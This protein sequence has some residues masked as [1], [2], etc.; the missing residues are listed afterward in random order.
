[1][2]FMVVGESLKNYSKGSPRMA[3][4]SAHGKTNK[5]T[6]KETRPRIRAAGGE[7]VVVLGLWRPS[8]LPHQLLPTD[9]FK[10]ITQRG[11][12]LGRRLVGEGTQILTTLVTASHSPVAIRSSEVFISRANLW[13]RPELSYEDKRVGGTCTQRKHTLL[14]KWET[15][16]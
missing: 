6:K 4:K 11:G 14:G 13:L 8:S 16:R 7:D 15:W 9:I 10:I 5:Q 1:M 12:R 2:S 3:G